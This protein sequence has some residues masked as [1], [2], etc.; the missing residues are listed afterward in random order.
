[1]STRRS[2]QFVLAC[3]TCAGD[4][5]A[6][7]V[8]CEPDPPPHPTLRLFRYDEDYSSLADP[9]ARTGP[10][11]AIKYV[12]LW[13]EH[14]YVSFGG[15]AR[16]QFES[17]QPPDL[18][19]AAARKDDYWLTRV[20]LHA[21]VHWSRTWRSF[22]EVLDGRAFG[23]ELDAPASQAN[24]V[25][26]Q[27][28]FAEYADARVSVRAGRM[29]MGFGSYRLVAPREGTNARAN[30]DGAR[31][32]VRSGSK[33]LD[34]FVT[35]PVEQ[36]TGAFDDS[37]N[38]RELFWGAYGV[39][40]LVPDGAL[41]LDVYYLGIQRDDVQYG[42]L[43]GS[44][45]RHSTGV[46][47]WGD[48]ARFDYDVEALVQFGRFAG[49]EIRAWT[50]ASSVGMRL[51]VGERAPRAG[52]KANVASGDRD[53]ADGE[54]GTFDPLFPRNAY[55]SEAALFRPSNFYDVQPLVQFFPSA[56]TTL[57]LAGDAFFR[58]DADDAVDGP[59]G[60]LI[61]GGVGGDGLVGTTGSVQLEWILHENVDLSLSY[62]RFWAGDVTRDAGGDDVDFATV[63]LAFRF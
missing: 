21:D 25:E 9:R 16:L 35:R 15:E 14:A 58:F 11:D 18:G 62:V 1:M 37:A 54:L 60:A 5:N 50:V 47:V 38:D 59:G 53:P 42:A 41:S 39:V 29:E 12:P 23:E 26:L 32:G 33:V 61:A 17:Y 6:V 31:V 10:F 49:D 46:R 28:A 27:Q 30:Y 56:S 40:P 7:Q 2:A 44:E 34:V 45:E 4:A 20:E 55:F 3:A 24:A 57:T 8:A 63:S 13:S 19:L 48:V 52:L 51:G 22:V 43:E 36:G